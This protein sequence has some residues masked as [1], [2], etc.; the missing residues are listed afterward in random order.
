MQKKINPSILEANILYLILGIGLLTLGGMA[1]SLEIYSGLLIT[2]YII[3][4]LPNLLYLH[5]RGYSLK[6]VLRLNKINFKQI[7]LVILITLATYPLAVFLQAIWFSIIGSFTEINA[8]GVPL[9]EN[10]VQYLISFFIIAITPGICEEI[11]FRGVILDSYERI[12][13]KKSIVITA[14]LFAIFHFTIFNMVGPFVIG[15][16]FGI[17]VYKTN[18]IYASIIGHIT[19][20]GIALTLGYILNKYY[21]IID[22]LASS[23]MDTS[24]SGGVRIGIALLILL[25]IAFVMIVIMIKNLSSKDIVADHEYIKE[26]ETM[27]DNE[28]VEEN[29]LIQGLKYFPVLI[30]VGIF[31]F[32]NWKYVLL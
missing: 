21:Y 26:V 5:F 7:I 1:Q 11:M 15:I 20:N 9:P 10:G 31:I 12:G 22:D 16:I 6:K 18:S 4:L 8:T 27:E 24:M 13:R 19:N 29:P 2:E 23:E 32:V 28:V 3:I 14:F 30:I 25:A 17:M